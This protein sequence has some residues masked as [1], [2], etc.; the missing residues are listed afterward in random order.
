[1][2]RFDPDDEESRPVPH[3]L[4]RPWVHPSELGA[5]AAGGPP[6]PVAAAPRRRRTWRRDT[7]L[8]LTAGATGALAT[9]TVLAL[10]GAFEPGRTA[11]PKAAATT[12]AATN[13]AAVATS[14][15]PGIGAVVTALGTDEERRGSGIVV[16]P[17]E[18]LTTADVVA[19]AAMGA[20]VRVLVADGKPL[21]ATVRAVDDLTGLA[22]VAV[23]DRVLQPAQMAGAPS[24]HAGD[25]IVVV[26]RTPTNGPWVS[27]GV[28]TATGG[29]TRDAQGRAHPGLITTNTDLTED[30]RGGALVDAGGHIVGIL[31]MGN[32]GG[33]RAVATP[34]DLAG[35]VADQ[36]TTEG[37]ATHGALGVRAADASGGPVIA[38]VDDDSAAAR[39][40]LRVEDRIVAVD[41]TQTPD[42]ATLVYELRRRHAGTRA[43]L[44]IQRGGRRLRV[45][46]TLDDAG[47]ASTE[48]ATGATTVALGTGSG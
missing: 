11:T 28:V 21:T 20:P 14:V 31:A 45:A 17:H 30:A 1:M 32:A 13:A 8:A 39:A 41:S 25:W 47:R 6:R 16:G 15:A 24:V 4:D 40:G 48:A 29:W 22:L 2:P 10:I 38:E 33:E 35:D 3:P 5:G 34:A 44:V 27:S 46:V 23:P 7:L 42:T 37:R 18:V 43:V 12:P 26:G 9:V 19:P 36:L